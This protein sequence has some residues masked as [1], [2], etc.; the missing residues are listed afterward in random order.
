MGRLTLKPSWSAG[1]FF[2][3]AVFLVGVA[4]GCRRPSAAPP[5]APKVRVEGP[6][7]TRFGYSVS[8]FDGTDDVDVTGTVKV[9]PESGVYSEDLK[10]GHQGVAVQVTPNG[11][12]TL[13][14]ILLDGAKELHRAT[15]KGAD[16]TAL[17]TAGKVGAVGPFR[18]P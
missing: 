15:A 8:Y 6:A 4:P 1:A 16:D 11:P 7:G 5:T 12:A 2:L 18:K 14:V 9:I 10:G 17:V 13:T 3:L